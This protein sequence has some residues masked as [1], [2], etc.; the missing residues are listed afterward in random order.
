MKKNALSILVLFIGISFMFGL[1]GCQQL[2]VDNLTANYHIQKA[3]SAYKEEKYKKAVEEYEKAL[4]LNPKLTNLY[5]YIGTGCSSLYRP[6]KTDDKN[7]NLGE[8]AVEFLLKAREAFPDKEEIVIA[9]GDIH[10]KMN[11][12]EES[13]KYYKMIMDKE[14]DNPKS[15]YILAD[16]YSKYNKPELAEAM[17]A[18]RIA[19]DVNDP[20]GY[21][22]YAS[23]AGERRQWDKSIEY[24]E[25]RIYAM[26]DPTILAV[27]V[28]I[29]QLK[30][31]IKAAEGIQKNIDTVKKHPKLDKAEKER[32]VGEAQ[33]K[34][35]KFKPADEM[36]AALENKGKELE[37]KLKTIDESIDKLDDK[38]K[39]AV[40]VAFYVL[41]NVSWNKSYQTPDIMMGS[42]ERLAAIEKGMAAL[43]KTLRINA[44]DDHAYVYIGLLWREKIRVHP[45]KTVE[46]TANW[47]KASE[48]GKELRDRKYKREQLKKQLEQMGDKN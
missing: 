3:N 29:D 27:K 45:T 10:D 18:K 41:G 42:E 40:S 38:K 20:E 47:K 19:L 8:K 24:H 13:E 39:I 12:F 43:D 6:M 15:Y 26:V 33:E 7:K 34:L 2:E 5:I 36:T 17:Y 21:Y 1:V 9:L 44:D 11:Q 35:D 32:L 37:E 23:W 31:D 4:E 28:E 46:Y 16:F 25:K 30:A 48:K 22:Y 14:P